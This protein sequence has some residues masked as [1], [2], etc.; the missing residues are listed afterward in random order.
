MNEQ[1]VPTFFMFDLKIFQKTF[2]PYFPLFLH[3][4]FVLCDFFT[5][6]LALHY[7]H[8]LFFSIFLILLLFRS[9]T[10]TVPYQIL[11]LTIRETYVYSHIPPSHPIQGSSMSTAISL[12]NSSMSTAISLQ[13]SS[14]YSHFPPSHFYVKDSSMS[15]AISLQV[16]SM[17]KTVLYLQPYPSKS[18]LCPQPYAK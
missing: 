10:L 6:D 3:C 5:P 13:N 1:N 7:L 9:Y 18:L 11:T 8:N 2:Q 15:P 4:Y 16:T 14:V 17:S 12:Q